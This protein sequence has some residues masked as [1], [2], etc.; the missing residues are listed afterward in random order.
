[1]QTDIEIW[2]HS[3]LVMRKKIYKTLNDPRCH[4]LVENVLKEWQN[5]TYLH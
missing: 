5:M 4:T 1:M 2:L 3:H